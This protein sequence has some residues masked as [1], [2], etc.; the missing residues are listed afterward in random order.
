MI[1]ERD[2]LIRFY[3]ICLSS[4]LEAVLRANEFGIIYFYTDPLRRSLCWVR[5]LWLAD[6]L[7]GRSC[8]CFSNN[9]VTIALKLD[10]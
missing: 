4:L 2:L 9:S 10:I 5:C 3:I 7:F 6:L 1:S 8:I